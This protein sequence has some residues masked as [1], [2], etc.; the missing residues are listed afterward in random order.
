M[1][2]RLQ[3]HLELVAL[4]TVYLDTVGQIVKQIIG[5]VYDRLKH[6]V[7]LDHLESS[8][9]KAKFLIVL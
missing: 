8:Y 6:F 5:H 3:H 4:N 7:F 9:T 1:A 2:L